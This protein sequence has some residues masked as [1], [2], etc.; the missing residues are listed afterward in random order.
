MNSTKLRSKNLILFFRFV[1]FYLLTAIPSR[2]GG[3]KVY[4]KASRT[5]QIRWPSSREGSASTK[6][7]RTLRT[8]QIKRTNWILIHFIVFPFVNNDVLLKKIK[9]KTN[10]ENLK[11]L[12]VS[13]SLC[14]TYL[15]KTLEKKKV[16]CK[17]YAWWDYIHSNWSMRSL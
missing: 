9:I 7:R 16:I 8:L 13:T 5:R 1:Y 11:L 4:R 14:N 2:K 10:T 12:I 6:L 3:C 17:L 15:F